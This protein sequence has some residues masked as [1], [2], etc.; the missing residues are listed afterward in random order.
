MPAGRLRSRYEKRSILFDRG[1]DRERPRRARD[2]DRQIGEPES[3]RESGLPARRCSLQARRRWV[4]ADE[5][6]F[7]YQRIDRRIERGGC[8]PYLLAISLDQVIKSRGLN[9]ERYLGELLPLA[10]VGIA[11]QHHRNPAQ[12][13]RDDY[14]RHRSTTVFHLA[15]SRAFGGAVR[16]GSGNHPY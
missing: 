16:T 4:I 11:P 2:V 10:A 3:S 1:V 13:Q 6:L 7:A 14:Y 12:P 15:R 5:V 8:A 9:P